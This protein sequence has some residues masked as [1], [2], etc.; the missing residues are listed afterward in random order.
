MHKFTR[1]QEIQCTTLKMFLGTCIPWVLINKSAPLV[2]DLMSRP[3]FKTKWR[4][5][6][7][8]FA[9]QQMLYATLAPGHLSFSKSGPR[10]KQV[11]CPWPRPNVPLVFDKW[12]QHF[13]KLV[14][15]CGKAQ[16]RKCKQSVH[17]IYVHVHPIKA[18]SFCHLQAQ[19]VIITVCQHYGK[20]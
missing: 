9:K 2:W 20:D 6:C 7:V 18:L 4:S 17:V 10:A 1:M 12:R 8:W 16:H 19:I 15:H 11:E 14:Q 3:L 13:L 5:Y